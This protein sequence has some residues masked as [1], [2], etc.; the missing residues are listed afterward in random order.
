MKFRIVEIEKYPKA[1]IYSVIINESESTEFEKFIGLY[2]EK[3]KKEVNYLVRKINKIGNFLGIQDEFFKDQGISAISRFYN[4]K[5][6]KK[7]KTRLRL[8]CIRRGKQ[9]LIVGGGGFKP[10]D[11]KRWQD[12]DELKNI[13][14]ILLS[15]DLYLHENKID[16][17]A[18]C[19][20]KTQHEIEE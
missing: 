16:I 19:N 17:D 6:N 14:E 13:V 7:N 3:Y 8:Y 10:D 2:L 5:T 12:V 18:S 1:K 11:K 15:I 20:N 9:C 4:K